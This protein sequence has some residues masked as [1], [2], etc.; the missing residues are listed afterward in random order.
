MAGSHDLADTRCRRTVRLSLPRSAAR[1][2]TAAV[3]RDASACTM[4][5]A[6]TGTVQP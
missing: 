2:R 4:A 1:S 5:T 6:L 3:H